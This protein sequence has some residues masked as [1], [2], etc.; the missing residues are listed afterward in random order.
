M[1]DPD[2]IL[3]ELQEYHLQT[4]L[5]E[6]SAILLLRMFGKIVRKKLSNNENRESCVI[7]V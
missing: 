2:Q 4:A 6:I 5:R 3:T 1:T 7:E